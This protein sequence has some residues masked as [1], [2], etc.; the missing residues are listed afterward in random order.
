MR[1]RIDSRA[2]IFT[3]VVTLAE[4]TSKFRREGLDVEAAWQAVRSLSRIF[5][6]DE[7]DAKSA[8]ILHATIKESRSNFSLADAFALQAARKLNCRILTDPDFSWNER[9]DYARQRHVSEDRSRG[10]RVTGNRFI[11]GG[12]GNG[13]SSN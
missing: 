12:I 11:H 2:E 13:S 10:R 9:S 8:G 1:K 4:L 6:I 3:H 7:S 5:I